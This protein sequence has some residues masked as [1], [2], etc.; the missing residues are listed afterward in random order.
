[1]FYLNC[2][3]KLKYDVMLTKGRKAIIFCLSLFLFW[4][5]PHNIEAKTKV[6]RQ[7]IVWAIG[8]PFIAVKA[9]KLSKRALLVT[10]SLEKACV[11]KDRSGGQLD[12]FKHAF[13]MALLSQ[14]IKVKKA[15]KLGAAHEKFNYKQCKKRKGGGDKAASDMDL[16]N[17]DV[18]L[19]IGSSHKNISETELIELIVEA[20]KKG[21]MRII[22]KNKDGKSLDS[23]GKLIDNSTL[24]TWLN[25][26]YLVP[27]NE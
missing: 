3:N 5:F 22:K 2:E 23:E 9:K 24:K 15:R 7:E 14:Q 17:N 12:A 25:K 16:W 13:W 11:L 8:H 27:S 1:M 10:D 6:S 26:R 18:G 19:K 4:I 20:I 21:E